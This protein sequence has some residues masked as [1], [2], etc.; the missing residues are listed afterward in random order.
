[1]D[2]RYRFDTF[3]PDSKNRGGFEARSV[4]L[5]RVFKVNTEA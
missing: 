5:I 3:A 1:M 2:K 4:S